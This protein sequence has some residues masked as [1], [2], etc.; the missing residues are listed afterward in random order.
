VSFHIFHV[1]EAYSNADGTVQF[2][3]FHGE[4]DGQNLWAGHTLTVTKAGNPTHTFNFLTNLPNGQT[5]GKSVLVATQAFADLTGITPNYIIPS[6]FLYTTGTQSINFPGMD[7]L[8]NFILPTD[9]EHSIGEDGDTEVNSPRNFAG[10]TGT[11]NP[12]PVLHLP[13]AD[14]F[15]GA[16][17][18]FQLALPA[19]TFTDI[20]DALTYSATL[21]GGDSLPGWLLF[22]SGTRTF[23]G[24]PTGGDTGSVS[25]EVS[26]SDGHGHE[27][28]DVFVITVISGD[29]VSG[30]GGA[31]SLTGSA[32]NDLISGLGGDD[33]IEGL[34]GSDTISGGAGTDTLRSTTTETLPGDVENLVLLGA[35]NINGTGNALANVLTGN[36]GNN[37]LAGDGGADTLAGGLGNDTFMVDS[38][39]DAVTEGLDEGE[40]QI[41]AGLTL[42]ALAANV[43]NLTLTGSGNFNATGNALANKLTGNGGNNILDG[44]VGVDTMAGGAGNDSYLVD[45]TS[46]VVTDSSGFDRV[47]STASFTLGTGVESLTLTGTAISGTGNELDNTIKGNSAANVLSGGAGSD[48]L[49][50]GTGADDFVFDQAAGADRVTD[51]L[52]GTDQLLLDNAVFAALVSEGPL[53]AGSLQLALH[54]AISDTSG[55]DAADGLQDYLKYATDTGELYYDA[56]GTAAGG[57]QL[58]ATLSK[59]GCGASAA[60]PV[61]NLV[62][63]QDIVVI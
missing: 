47:T 21:Q 31:D 41:L 29:V 23:S 16:G 6:N 7:D 53:A 49:T 11:I 9:G 24:T 63:A 58:I 26:A 4:A 60:H 2:I 22:D 12:N 51:F 61:I 32:D 3:E 34:G 43:E 1:S 17:D 20:N 54:G 35:G 30:T 45:D 15:A 48:T 19:N 14:Q 52:S 39:T 33:T 18:A 42:P 50:G 46:D 10:V 55:D 28:T 13:V 8:S 62:T 38:T 40:D 59:T 5:N 36:S 25:V 44:G 57:L 37:E 27:A 56:N